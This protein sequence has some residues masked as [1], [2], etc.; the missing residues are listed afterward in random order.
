M[1][2]SVNKGRKC[3][4]IAEEGGKSKKKEEEEEEMS[5]DLFEGL[6]SVVL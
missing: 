2:S 5:F 4:M 1:T 3:P 6:L